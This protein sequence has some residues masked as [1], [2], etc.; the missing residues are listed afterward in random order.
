MHLLLGTD[1]LIGHLEQTLGRVLR[2]KKPEE[3]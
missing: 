3:M 2:R 1:W